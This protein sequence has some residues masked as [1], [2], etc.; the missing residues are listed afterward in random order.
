M[1]RSAGFSLGGSYSSHRPPQQQHVP[2]VSG[3]GVSFTPGNSQDLLHLHGSDLFPSSHASYHSQVSLFA[4]NFSCQD[5]RLPKIDL[6]L[7]L[8]SLSSGS[9][10]WAT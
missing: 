7:L 8:V 3:S 1:G 6:F 2:S 10:Q 5:G 9:D 4:N